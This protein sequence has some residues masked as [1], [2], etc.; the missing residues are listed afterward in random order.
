MDMFTDVD[1]FADIL[2]AAT[3]GVAVYVL[4]DELNAQHFVAMVNNCRVNLDE[5]KVG[6]FFLF[7]CY[8]SVQI[9]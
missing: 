4:L 2:G 3:R 5:I 6:T 9:H 1:I 8:K 7:D